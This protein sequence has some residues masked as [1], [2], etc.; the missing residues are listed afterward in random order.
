M[1]KNVAET[2]VVVTNGDTYR[3]RCAETGNWFEALADY[4]Y[5][6]VTYNTLKEAEA[7]AK[8][9]SWYPI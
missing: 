6:I 7:K 8:E 9:L 5:V 1:N 2:W 4:S 3:L